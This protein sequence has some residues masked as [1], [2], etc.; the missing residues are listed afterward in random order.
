MNHCGFGSGLSILIPLHSSQQ[1][2]SSSATG[3]T[4][5]ALSEIPNGPD[6]RSAYINRDDPHERLPL[7]I[8]T[9]RREDWTAEELAAWEIY[10]RSL[11]AEN[12][13]REGT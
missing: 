4:P 13:G 6:N 11:S 5:E 2:S 7:G 1:N 3:L 8:S 9:A 12:G 10:F